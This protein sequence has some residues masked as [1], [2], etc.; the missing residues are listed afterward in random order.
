MPWPGKSNK[1]PCAPAEDIPGLLKFAGEKNIDLT[2]VGPE[3]PLTEGIVDVFEAEGHKIFG[4]HKN[5][6]ILEGSK[7]FAKEFMARHKIPSGAFMVADTADQAGEILDSGR[8]TF[9]LVVKADGLAAG[10]GAIIC[11]NRE[12]AD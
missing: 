3:A 9:P 12:E 10:K 7:V 5:A 2:V 11:K 4:P 1:A 6:A 8:F